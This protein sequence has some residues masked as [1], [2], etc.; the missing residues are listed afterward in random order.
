[1]TVSVSFLDR[2]HGRI[3]YSDQGDGPLVVV[4][5]GLGDLK[6]EYRFLTPHLVSAGYR[7]VAMDL[8]GHG[9]STTGWRD[10]A[11]AAIG[12]DIVALVD[13]LKARPTTVI[14]TSMGAGA[15]AWAAAEA[16][17]SVSKLV[18]IGPFVRE[19]PKS[20][21]KNAL[22]KMI[23]H[24]AF[25]GS[26]GPSAWGMYYASL[27]PTAKPA[28][29]DSYKAGLVSNLKEPGRMAALQ[30]MLAASK[31]DVE[32]RLSEVRAPTLV[33]MGSKDPDFDDPAAEAATVARLLRGSATMVDD[34]GHYPH[35]EL[36]EKTTP[37]I[38]DFLA[39]KAGL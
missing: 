9:A 16:P 12:S 10:Y 19:L 3:A 8:R 15:A 5:P 36:P 25:V 28:D 24:T 27:Y 22:V 11:S 4:V 20:W 21:W 18:L 29:F 39:A 7:V 2:P 37:A 6:E 35:A 34:A 31:K 38:L 32:A 13:H 23:V 17:G 1:M 33:V 26:W 30:A 14:G